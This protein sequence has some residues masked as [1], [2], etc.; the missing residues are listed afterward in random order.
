[1]L[2]SS[3]LQRFRRAEGGA[4]AVEFA[5]LAL[6]LFTL[7]FA[8]LEL[9]VIFLISMTLDNAVLIASREIRTGVLQTAGAP[10]LTTFK[11]TICNNMAWIK[12]TCLTN[13]SLYSKVYP[14]FA[15][16]ATPANQ[17]NPVK[18]VGTTVTFDDSALPFEQGGPD[19]IV[20]VKAY[21]RWTI[22]MPT[23]NKS[24]VTLS[25]NQRVIT[26]TAVFQNEPYL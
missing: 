5:L 17:P 26:A 9:G 1:M 2:I 3:S 24:L 16:A 8:L 10:N 6:P 22:V 11:A 25:N 13:L 23:M 15:N 14:S 12:S 19:D 20:I 7:I 18:T 4:T 21:F